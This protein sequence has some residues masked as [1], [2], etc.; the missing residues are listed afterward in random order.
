MFKNPTLDLSTAVSATPAVV[1]ATMP[2][3]SSGLRSIQPA[4]ASTR[5]V[6]A[7]SSG[8]SAP[9]TDAPS[10]WLTRSVAASSA[11]CFPANSSAY[12]AASP[13]W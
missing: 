1:A 3:V 10:A 7:S 12:R 4:S 8:V 6:T 2:A 13:T 5:G 9:C 11:A